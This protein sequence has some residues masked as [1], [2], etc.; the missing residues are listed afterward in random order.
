[1]SPD[2]FLSWKDQR[3]TREVFTYLEGRRTEERDTAIGI[4]NKMAGENTGSPIQAV[5]R[6][7]VISGLNELLELEQAHLKEA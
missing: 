2:E 5:W 1:M 3:L 6:A 7:G 4:L